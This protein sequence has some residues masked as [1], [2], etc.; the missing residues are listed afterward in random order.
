MGNVNTVVPT[1]VFKEKK[2]VKDAA[3]DSAA[4]TT[5]IYQQED[6]RSEK[7]LESTSNLL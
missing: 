5:Q 6:V 4:K 1:Y 2:Y 3:T 7:K